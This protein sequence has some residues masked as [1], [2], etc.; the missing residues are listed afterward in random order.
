[1]PS[2]CVPQGLLGVVVPPSPGQKR[3]EEAWAS[4][5]PLGSNSNSLQ[6]LLELL[7]RVLTEELNTEAI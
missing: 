4:L 7:S 5:G 1:M 3:R 2:R 6:R